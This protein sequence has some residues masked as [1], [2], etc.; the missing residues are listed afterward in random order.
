VVRDRAG[1]IAETPEP[2][3]AEP[4]RTTIL[5]RARLQA[6]LQQNPSLSLFDASGREVLRPKSIPRGIYFVRRPTADGR[7]LPAS[8]KVLVTD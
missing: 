7:Q 3:R 2:E 6:E 4:L 1:G 5:T 8:R